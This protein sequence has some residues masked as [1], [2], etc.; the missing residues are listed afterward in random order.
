MARNRRHRRLPP[1][2]AKQPK[3]LNLKSFELFPQLPTELRLMVWEFCLPGPRVVDIRM[4]R[5]SI[6]TST[7]ELLDVS[8]F[9]SSV[10]HPVM[11]HVCSESRRLARQH[12]RLAFPKKTKTEWSPAKIYVD[13]SIDTIWFDNLRYFPSTPSTSSPKTVP[14]ADFARIKYLAMRHE[15][16]RVLLDNTK[17][18]DPKHFPAL[19][20]VYQIDTVVQPHQVLLVSYGRYT[21]QD[22]DKVWEKEEKC[23]IVYLAKV[24]YTF[25]RRSEIPRIVR[26]RIREEG[27]GDEKF[28]PRFTPALSPFSR[29]LTPVGPAERPGP[30]E[31]AELIERA[32]PIIHHP[33][34]TRQPVLLAEAAV[35]K[36]VFTERKSDNGSLTNEQMDNNINFYNTADYSE[37][38]RQVCVSTK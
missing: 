8:R 17:L 22:W 2:P 23:P 34:T 12:Y 6:P 38:E 27:S 33:A 32:E 4:C 11:L 14:K 35:F 9:I 36:P 18:L 25:K 30:V 19:E 20:A 16:E 24:Q 28:Y 21:S 31:P 7:G 10:D 26:G 15:V 13:F 1:L 3:S 29:H 5:K 37:M